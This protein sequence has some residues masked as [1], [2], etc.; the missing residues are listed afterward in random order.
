MIARRTIDI[1]E[2]NITSNVCLFGSAASSLWTDI[3]RV[4]QVCATSYIMSLSNS[5]PFI[6]QDIDIVVTPDSYESLDAEEIAEEIKE[7]IVQADDRY[8]L[9][10]PKSR[11]ATYQILY[12]RLRGWKTNGRCVKVDILVPPT[13]ELPEVLSSD[14]VLINGISVMPLFDLLVMK[15]KGW[16]DHSTS[17]RPD[18]RDKEATDVSDIYALLDHAKDENVSYDYEL[19]EDRHQDGFMDLAHDLSRRFVG[20][21]GR[22]GQWR[23]LGFPI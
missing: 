10:P 3:G 18:F 14:T 4:P 23:R 5:N 11:W 13:L 20:V 16:W 15:T 12:C 7:T 22:P 8:F 21:Y 17:F 19:Y 1:I 6:T 9:Q 2:F